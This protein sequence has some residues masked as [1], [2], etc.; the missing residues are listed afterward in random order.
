MLTIYKYPLAIADSQ[1]IVMPHNSVPLSVGMQRETLCLWASVDTDR[2]ETEHEVR[3]LG[4]GHEASSILGLR[5][6]C[7]VHWK[8]LGTVQQNGGALIWHVFI[9]IKPDNRATMD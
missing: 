6:W 4:T 8:F 1:R 2:Q 5:S 7:D 9:E 3:I